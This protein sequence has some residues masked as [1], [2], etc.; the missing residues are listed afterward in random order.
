M[1][2]PKC[3]P[4]YTVQSIE[5]WIDQ[6]LDVPLGPEVTLRFHGENVSRLETQ[7]KC[8][9]WGSFYRLHKTAYG[10]AQ[11]VKQFHKDVKRMYARPHGAV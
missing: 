9:R 11:S 4:R 5:C 2:F 7:H 1:K 3:F 8:W 6:A 10:A